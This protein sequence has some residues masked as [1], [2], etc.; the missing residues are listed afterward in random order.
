MA[1]FYKYEY[2]NKRK[3]IHPCMHTYTCIV[4]EGHQGSAW[5]VEDKC[6]TLLRLRV[7]KK[8]HKIVPVLPITL[9]ISQ[10]RS[11]K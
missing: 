11:I 10:F 8:Q 7:V 2:T 5:Q 9:W 4:Y 3:N 1:F 6:N